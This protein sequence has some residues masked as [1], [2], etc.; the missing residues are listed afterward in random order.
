M[1][2]NVDL[3]DRTLAHIEANPEEW[4]QSVYRC[5]TGMCFAGW[6]CDLAGGEWLNAP[7][8][9]WPDAL[10]AEPTDDPLRVVKFGGR[11]PGVTASYR[12]MRLLGITDEQADD[13]FEAQNALAELREIVAE[14]KA[15]AS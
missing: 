15:G 9:H 8:D 6:V 7:F 13:L 1:S 4:K 14:I 11:R 5:E 10:A 12:A 3:L 2:V